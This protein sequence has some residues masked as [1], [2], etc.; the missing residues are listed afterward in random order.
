[1]AVSVHTKLS[2]ATLEEL[3]SWGRRKSR[4]G[5]WRELPIEKSAGNV[6]IVHA[7]CGALKQVLRR[8]NQTHLAPLD[9]G[10]F[11]YCRR[12]AGVLRAVRLH[13]AHPALIHRDI[14]QFFPSVSAERVFNMLLR[15][16]Y[17]RR[18]AE[19][20]KSVCTLG[21]CLVQG[22]PTSVTV[23]NLVL[24][25]LDVRLGELA[26]VNGLTYTRY[27]DDLA[28]SGGEHR[29]RRVEG[30]VD[31][32]IKEDGWSC[33]SKGGLYPA[34]S[35]REYLGVAVGAELRVGEKSKARALSAHEALERGDIDYATF[36]ARTNWV[37][38]VEGPAM[39]SLPNTGIPRSSVAAGDAPE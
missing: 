1:M 24:A 29:L 27:V 5:V 22:S 39:P 35:Y 32:I 12:G 20:I 36:Q 37:R 34:Q 19:A 13:R 31:R 7:P 30:L 9:R 23:G 6:R 21:N 3:I 26:R 8:L 14:A 33:S 16:G 28:L 10:Q 38:A 4:T 2:Q 25:R 11:S 18:S 17:D 15:R